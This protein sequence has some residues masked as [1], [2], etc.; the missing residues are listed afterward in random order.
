MPHFLEINYWVIIFLGCGKMNC[1]FP[2]HLNYQIRNFQNYIT[3]CRVSHT[4]QF[5]NSMS[6]IPSSHSIK[7]NSQSFLR[8]NRLLNERISAF[9]E[10]KHLKYTWARPCNPKTTFVSYVG[11]INLNVIPKISVVSA[12]LSAWS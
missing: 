11:I 4:K 12:E 2:H 10:L 9:I 6:A 1:N 8:A 7:K 5:C 3:Y